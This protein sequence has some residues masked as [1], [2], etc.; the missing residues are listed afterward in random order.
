[1]IRNLFSLKAGFSFLI[2][3]FLLLGNLADVF[4][5]QPPGLVRGHANK[6]VKLCGKPKPSCVNDLEWIFRC[7][8]EKAY[9]LLLK[10]PPIWD[11]QVRLKTGNEK[12]AD[13]DDNVYVQ[14][15]TKANSKVFLDRLKNDYE[16]GNN[17]WY[18]VVGGGVTKLSDINRLVVGMEGTDG[19]CFS[20][21]VIKINEGPTLATLTPPG[22]A[23]KWLDDN[24]KIRFIPRGNKFTLSSQDKHRAIRLPNIIQLRKK[25]EAAIGDS[26]GKIPGLSW[27]RKLPE[28]EVLVLTLDG[29][30]THVVALFTYKRKIDMPVYLGGGSE[31]V[32]AGLTL[33]FDVGVNSSKN[34]TITNPKLKHTYVSVSG[35]R[36]GIAS[37]LG[38]DESRI[39]KELK[40]IDLGKAFKGL[41]VPLGTGPVQ[42]DFVSFRG[43][44]INLGWPDLPSTV[45]AMVNNEL[46][47]GPI[48]CGSFNNIVLYKAN[49]RTGKFLEVEVSGNT[50]NV[51]RV[52]THKDWRPIWDIVV[53]GYFGSSSSNRR[54]DLLFYD[55]KSGKAESYKVSTNG[56]VKLIKSFPKWA[57]GWDSIIPGQYNNDGVTDLLFYDSQKGLGLFYSVDSSG[58]IRLM[59]KNK[60]RKGWDIIIPGNFNNDRLTDLFFYNKDKGI[61]KFYRTDGSG[62]IK[63]IRKNNV[64]KA[65]DIVVPINLNGDRYTD[66]LFYRKTGKASFYTTDGAGRLNH[67]RTHQNWVKNWDYIVP[68]TPGPDGKQ[69]LIFYKKSNGLAK[70]HKVD[71]QGGVSNV[72]KKRWAKN[73]DAIVSYPK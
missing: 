36:G 35:F 27:S 13:T 50:A 30:T 6:F 1:M 71:A 61:G 32:T 20:R 68:L 17:D 52:R 48:R 28:R 64:A 31:K 33:K 53:P 54:G 14:F 57:K 69:A 10:D 16:K 55:R 18:H 15:N 8:Y 63:I 4:A 23:C 51:K 59:R 49:T 70:I 9:E 7:Q 26:I 67:I 73:W 34:I 21:A 22:G 3:T 39:R 47:P 24:G 11:I 44:V 58:G 25:I 60:W 42:P 65:W 5:Q 40:K 38:I 45:V 62:R 43:D 2:V 37:L 29:N 56:K 41:S 12:N 19:W 72:Y 66:L 46:V